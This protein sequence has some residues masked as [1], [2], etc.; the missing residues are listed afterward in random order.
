VTPEPA[1]F[2]EVDARGLACPR[3]IIELARAARHATPG[4]E[5]TVWCTDPAALLDVP[6]WARLTGNAYVGERERD[7]QAFAL[8][9]RLQA[10]PG[11]HGGPASASQHASA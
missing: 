5:I 6:A 3:P 9:V 10:S 8:T 4:T 1:A 11:P 7:A 2:L